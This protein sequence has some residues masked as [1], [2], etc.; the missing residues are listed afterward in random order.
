[1]EEKDS[2]ANKIL[3][4]NLDTNDHKVISYFLLIII[5]SIFTFLAMY[6]VLFAECGDLGCAVGSGIINTILIPTLWPI[7]YLSY[8]LITRVFHLYQP[9]RII[10]VLI[11]STIMI[12]ALPQIWL[13]IRDKI[14]YQINL[15]TFKQFQ[16]ETRIVREKIVKTQLDKAIYTYN[17]ELE[18]QNKTKT[19]FL[20]MPIVVWVDIPAQERS[21]VPQNNSYSFLKDRKTVDLFPG[22]TIIQGSIPIRLIPSE[23]PSSEFK[24]FLSMY[25]DRYPYKEDYDNKFR[26]TKVYQNESKLTEWETVFKEQ[27]N[28]ERLYGIDHSDESIAVVSYHPKD[29]ISIRAEP[30]CSPPNQ[31]Y[32]CA[33]DPSN[34]LNLVIW[35]DVNNPER[36]KNIEIWEEPNTRAD[37]KLVIPI[38]LLPTQT[39]E[40]LEENIN[41]LQLT[42]QTATIS[43]S[44][45]VGSTGKI[46]PSGFLDPAGYLSFYI[47]QSEFVFQT[48][49]AN[50]RLTFINKENIESSPILITVKIP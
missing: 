7:C 46:T 5:S 44:G 19:S 27:S 2:T 31:S 14:V 1:M 4:N 48:K 43:A 9:Q 39:I 47:P 41:K 18:I 38:H 45:W 22:K 13:P 3:S 32:A 23:L 50:F 37:Y 34:K 10:R 6:P 36:T 20:G 16:I 35:L 30:L 25:I 17:Y 28:L 29:G 12:F 8:A 21:W 15:N 40:Q 33:V 49:S 11:I 42:S 26:L 24:V